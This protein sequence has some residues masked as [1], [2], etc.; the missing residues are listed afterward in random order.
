MKQQ[1]VKILNELE[2]ARSLAWR[3]W[4]FAE[5]VCEGTLYEPTIPSYTVPWK[6]GNRTA[7]QQNL[8]FS[9]GLSQV[10]GYKKIGKHQTGDAFHIGLRCRRTGRFIRYKTGNEEADQVFLL[11]A[12]RAEKMGLVWGGRWRKLKDWHHFET[13]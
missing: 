4:G 11:I 7:E 5:S 6:S 9:R 13:A 2:G 3:L 1:E 12:E 8:L 10:D